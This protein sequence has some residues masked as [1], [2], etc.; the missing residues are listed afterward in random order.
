MIERVCDLHRL[1]DKDDVEESTLSLFSLLL[2][3]AGEVLCSEEKR[4]QALDFFGNRDPKPKT[5]IQEF[6]W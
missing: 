4:V 5:Q 1:K 3:P 6:E 2:Q